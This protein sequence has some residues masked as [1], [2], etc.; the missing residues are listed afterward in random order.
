MDTAQS[1]P[2]WKNVWNQTS[3]LDFGPTN[4]CYTVAEGAWDKGGGDWSV[5]Q[6]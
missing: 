2:S 1:E 3:D 6:K 5:Y 4:N